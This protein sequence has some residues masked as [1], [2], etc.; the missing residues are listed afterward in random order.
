[1]DTCLG[2]IKQARNKHFVDA[3]ASWD[4]ASYKWGYVEVWN[5]KRL[6]MFL[7]ESRLHQISGAC[8]GVGGIGTIGCLAAGVASAPIALP[9]VGGVTFVAGIVHR[10]T[11]KD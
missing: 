7:D 8:L 2:E 1:M 6:G 4:V 10:F 5:G 3:R 9:I 11:G